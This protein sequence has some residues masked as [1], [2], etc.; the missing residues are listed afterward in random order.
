MK[1][2]TIPKLKALAREQGYKMIALENAQGERVVSFNQ[3]NKSTDKQFDVIVTRLKSE[4]Q[5]D[6]VYFILMAHNI[7][8]A[9]NPDRY[10]ITKGKVEPEVLAEAEKK[11]LPLTPVIIEKAENVLSWESAVEMNKT[12]AEQAA[13]IKQL[14][15]ENDQ[16]QAQLDEEPDALEEDNSGGGLVGAFKDMIPSLTPMLDRYFTLQEKKL[17]LDLLKL[18]NGTAKQATKGTERKPIVPGTQGHLDLIEFYFKKSETDETGGFEKKLNAELDKLEQADP[19]LYQ[20][21]LKALGM[22]EEEEEQNG[23]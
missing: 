15:F 16:L 1:T 5:P 6:G 22:D 7:S 10:P 2:Y 23:E 14:E 17:D 9:R 3:I 20:V 11:S 19:E 4:L 8:K 18:Q 12:I 13:R 21:T